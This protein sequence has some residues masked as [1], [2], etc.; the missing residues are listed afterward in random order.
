MEKK[1]FMKNAKN[2]I[3]ELYKEHEIIFITARCD[4]YFDKAEEVTLELLKDKYNVTFKDC[5]WVLNQT[6]TPA[7]TKLEFVKRVV[8]NY[9]IGNTDAHSKN[10]SL[11]F[12]APN[13][14]NLTPAYDLLCTSVYD[15]D[16]RI[17][18]KIGKAKFYKD[19]TE[20]DWELFAQDIDISPFSIPHK[21][22]VVICIFSANWSCVKPYLTLS[23][24]IFKPSSFFMFTCYLY[25]N[26]K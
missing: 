11:S 25:N 20:R 8:F 9:I 17:A 15:C 18:M 1:N 2:V 22:L 5:L 10:F 23:L 7:R 13:D 12:Y 19:V 6:T 16:Q 4:K 21:V 14:I 26:F 3:N 24:L